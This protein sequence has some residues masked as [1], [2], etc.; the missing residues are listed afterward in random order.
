MDKSA[1]IARL[2]QNKANTP[3][4]SVFS[5]DN[6]EAIDAMIETVEKDYTEDDIYQKF[7]SSYEQ[8]AALS[9][10]EVMNGSIPIE[11]ALFPEY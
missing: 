10:L 3:Q 5:D 7:N 2:Q 6:H 1:I 4:L 9:I 11:D 8:D